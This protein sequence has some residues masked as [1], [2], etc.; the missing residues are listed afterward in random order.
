[1]YWP[2]PEFAGSEAHI[3]HHS[4]YMLYME[5]RP[6]LA[7]FST[8]G[9]LLFFFLPTLGHHLLRW[10]PKGAELPSAAWEPKRQQG[11][12]GQRPWGWKLSPGAQDTWAVTGL[13]RMRRVTWSGFPYRRGGRFPLA[14]STLLLVSTTEVRGGREHRKVG[15]LAGLA[16]SFG[17]LEWSIVSESHPSSSA[18]PCNACDCLLLLHTQVVGAK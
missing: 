9:F 5:L 3:T 6:L 12:R 13:F 1:M 11:R 4:I 14:T 17:W 16:V 7:F 15:Q 8:Q 18:S 2:G 10:E